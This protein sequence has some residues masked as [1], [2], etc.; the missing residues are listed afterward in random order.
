MKGEL[1]WDIGTF[2]KAVNSIENY[3]IFGTVA[4]YEVYDDGFCVWVSGY[5]EPVCGEFLPEHITPMTDEEIEALIKSKV[6]IEEGEQN[7]KRN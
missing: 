4:A 2:V 6:F 5:K 3:T 1:P 7:G